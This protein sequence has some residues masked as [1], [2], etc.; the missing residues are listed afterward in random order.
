MKLRKKD[1][2]IKKLLTKSG[3]GAGS[4]KLRADTGGHRAK[5]SA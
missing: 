3:G 2:K 5:D 1:L 4:V